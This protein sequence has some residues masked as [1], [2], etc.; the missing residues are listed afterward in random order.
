MKEIKLPQIILVFA[1]AASFMY[2]LLAGART[3]I[4][5]PSDGLGAGWAQFSFLVTGAL[6]VSFLGLRTSIHPLNAIA[7]GV[8]LCCSMGLYEW[9]RHVIWGR[10]FSIAWSGRVPDSVCESGPYLYIRHPIYVSYMLAFL[11]AFLAM[12][13]FV[14]VGCV[15]FNTALFTHAAISDERSLTDSVLAEQYARYRTRTG[16]FFPRVFR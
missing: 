8:M 16:M 7:S 10:K 3:F 6:A 2:F 4:T 9:A 12:P 14:L 13:S 1:L 11:A 5:R 15:V